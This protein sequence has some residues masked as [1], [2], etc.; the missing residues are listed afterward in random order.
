MFITLKDRSR[1]ET[2][3]EKEW[4]ERAFGKRRNM[5]KVSLVYKPILPKAKKEGA[6]N[7]F[8]DIKFAM[9]PE[10]EEE[11]DPVDFPPEFRI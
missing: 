11:F 2:D 9:F 3:E 7:F 5:M 8:A 4:Y 1:K 10:M 6:F